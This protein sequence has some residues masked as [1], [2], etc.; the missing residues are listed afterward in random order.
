MTKENLS[1]EALKS[2]FQK[3]NLVYSLLMAIPLV[4][5]GWRYLELQ[6]DDLLTNTIGTP[7]QQIWVIIALCLSLLIVLY[8]YFHFRKKTKKARNLPSFKSKLAAYQ[9]SA[10]KMYTYL[11]FGSLLATGMLHF[12]HE[13]ASAALFAL[14]L[15]LFSVNRPSAEHVA[16]SLRLKK[17]ELLLLKKNAI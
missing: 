14:T 2:F 3:L 9:S 16:K 15:F 13:Q 1:S 6:K 5:F 11:F 8:A 12:T 10:K 4:L 17:E 7:D